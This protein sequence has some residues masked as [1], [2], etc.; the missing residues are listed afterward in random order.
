MSKDQQGDDDSE[1]IDLGEWTGEAPP[2]TLGKPRNIEDTR[3]T[4]AYCLFG[5]LGGIVAVLLG[6]VVFNGL[7][8]DEF[9]K[10]AAVTMSPVVGL[11]GAVSG[12]YY[13]RK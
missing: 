6:M 5:L 1:L 13:G 3:A 9:L 7:T 8:V 4:L 10:V 11:V 12:Y 2:P